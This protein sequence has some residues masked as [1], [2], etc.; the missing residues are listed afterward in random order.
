MIYIIIAVHNRKDLTRTCLTLLKEQAF[1]D[2][3]VIV[4]DDGSTDGTSEM[5]EKEF[6]ETILIKG[7]GSLWW[8]G[9]TNKGVREAMRIGR[10]SDYVLLLN[11]DLIFSKDYLD[12]LV[13]VSKRFPK[14]LI[15]SVVT[16]A[17]NK[18]IIAEGGYKKAI[19]RKGDGWVFNVG[20]K[21]SSFPKGHFEEVGALTGRGV[22]IPFKVFSDIGLYDDKHLKQCGDMELPT[23]ARLAGYRL[24]VSYDVVVH[25]KTECT[26]D[27]NTKV[28]YKLSDFKDYFFHVRSY[29]NIKYRF[30]FCRNTSK[31]IFYGTIRFIYD[32]ARVTGHFIKGLV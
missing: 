17:D 2:F 23:R 6:P 25:C 5:I 22:L 27:I 26:L 18:D 32:L 20:K 19:W 4:V 9:A 1:R 31:N 16:P 21:L 29:A 28:K 7:D 3:N 12:K 11:D 8:S 24:I 13:A 30:W 10:D 15:G 14:A